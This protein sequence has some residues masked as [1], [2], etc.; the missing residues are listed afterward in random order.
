MKQ[1]LVP[2]DLSATAQNALRQAVYLAHHTGA[3]IHVLHVFQLTLKVSY[4]SLEQIQALEKQEEFTARQEV[5]QLIFDALEQ[6]DLS[7]REKVRVRT[8]V[9]LGSPADD[10]LYFADHDNPDMVVMGAKGVDDYPDKYLGSNTLFVL[11]NCPVPVLIVPEYAVPTLPAKLLYVTDLLRAER[12]VKMRLLLLLEQLGLEL[13]LLHLDTDYRKKG[14]D[15]EAD[16]K[17]AEMQ[18][19]AFAQ[20]P[21]HLHHINTDDV[22]AGIARYTAELG[23]DWLGLSMQNT[24]IFD[25]LYQSNLLEHLEFLSQVPLLSVNVQLLD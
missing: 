17:F 13:H 24:T 8:T 14:L 1:I 7:V 6:F 5:N 23:P 2:H 16:E 3:E 18:E 20:V 4:K 25:R 12:K 11:A 19:G 21:I 15:V 9:Q 10:I 22:E